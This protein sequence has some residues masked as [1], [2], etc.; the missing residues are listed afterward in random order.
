MKKAVTVLTLT[1]FIFFDCFGQKLSLTDLSFLC[2]KKNW[3]DV[4]QYL[5]AKGWTYF[6]SEKGDTYKYNTITWSF[7]KDYYSDKAQGWFYLYTYEGYPNK[8]SYSVFNKESYYLIQNSISTA[9]FK[10]IDSEIEDNEVTSTYGNSSYT[11]S[12]SYAKRTDDDW[13]DRSVTAYKITLIKKAGIYD[14]DNGKKTAYFDDGETIQAEFELLDGKINGQLKAYHENGQL[15]KIGN[16]INGIENGLFK[17]YDEDGNI[18]AEYTMLNGLMNGSFKRYSNGKLIKSGS[19]IKGKQEGPFTEYD[20][21]GAKTAEYFMTNDM[22][23]GLVK[24]FEN[25]K[26]SYSTTFQNDIQTG[27][28][29]EYYYNEEDGE[30]SLI[31]YGEHLDDEKHGT[32]KLFIIEDGKERLLTVENYANGIK[33]GL[34]Q[35]IK[36]DSLIICTYKNE[37]L[38][39]EYKVY[40]D[41]SKILFGGVIRTKVSDLAL[42]SEG[43]YYNGLKNG[44]WKNYDI[45]GSLREEGSY[46][47]DL[48]NGEWRYY[49]VNLHDTAGVELPYAKKLYLIANYTNGKLN[50]KSTRYS[51]LT[52]EKY[53]CSEV[54]KTKSSFD[55]CTRDIYEKVLET[56]FYKDDKLD[57]PFE[58]KD[59]LGNIMAK[60]SFKNDLKDG[61]WLQRFASEDFYGKVYYYYQKGN[62]AADIRVGKWIQFVNENHIILTL[63][64][65]DGK[66]HGEYISWDKDDKPITKKIFN[67]G[68]LAEYVTYDSL[69]QKALM[70]YEIYDNNWNSFRCRETK[71]L[72][73]GY[74]SQEYLLYM[75]NEIDHNW[76]TLQFY[77]CIY[78]QS[79]NK[80]GYKDGE[81]KI[82]NLLNKPVV[83]GKYYKEDKVG[84]WTYYYYDQDVKI[85]SN[86]LQGKMNDEKYFKL[87]GELFSGEFVYNDNE[88]GVKETRKIKEGLRNGKTVYVDLKTDKTIKKESYE[89][90]V[91]K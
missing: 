24:V 23:N 71:Y 85:E 32:W 15:K 12:I 38:D 25:G 73:D 72:L 87:S 51:F 58:L 42:I 40:I 30:L 28:Y 54:D 59:S 88:N 83:T 81:F 47:N 49:Y 52:T 44:Y 55:T 43:R 50:G 35:E 76:F 66:F 27:K 34:F 1:L 4:N 10:L 6:D 16:Y 21:S 67:N 5:L 17:E 33:N 89:N 91:L 80:K 84:L 39:G 45:L 68:K 2:N 74:A 29:T 19:F 9:G 65:K 77:G 31:N 3:E 63:N 86:F 48:E 64:Y 13:Q 37:I 11:L 26:L 18:D 82:F 14:A 70:K 46:L 79:E 57:G 36:G 90:G 62:Y 56:S 22:K 20:E 7:K 8:I 78:N 69:G 75:E 61:E 41:I 60:G 53:P